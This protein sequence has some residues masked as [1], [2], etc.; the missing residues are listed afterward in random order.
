MRAKKCT[1]FILVFELIFLLT[2]SIFAQTISINEVVSANF[3]SATDE[4]GDNPD[5]LELYNYGSVP[6]NLMNFGLSDRD[7]ELHR[8]TFPDVTID[9]YDFLLVFASNKNRKISAYW[10]TIIDEGDNWKYFPGIQAPPP[11]WRAVTFNDINWLEGPSGFGAGDG[12]DNTVIPEIND[13]IANSVFLRHTFFVNNVNNILSALLNIDFDDAFVVWLN[14]VEIARENIGY[15]GDFP[16]YNDSIGIT[17]HEA[18]LYS[19]GDANYYLLEDIQ[20]LLQPGNNTLAIE[21]HTLDTDMTMIPFLTLG[22]ASEPASP[23]GVNPIVQS[24]IPNLHT[25][26]KI[27][28]T[29]IIYL[30]DANENE[31]DQLSAEG[32]MTDVSRG[33]QPDG[34]NNIYLF[35]ITTPD[36]MNVAIPATDILDPPEF[37]LLGGYYD[38]QVTIT[39]TGVNAEETIYVSADGSVPSDTSSTSIIYNNPIHITET[40]VLRARKY[41]SGSIPSEVVTNTYFINTNHNLP[42]ISLTSDPYNLFDFNYGIL[43]LGPNAGSSFPHLKA[44]FWQDWERPMHIELFE[45]DGTLGLKTD[46]G[47]KVFGYASRGHDQKSLA[48][49]ARSKYGANAFEYKFFEDK[50][51]DSFQSFVLR[52]SGGDWLQ[53][54]MRD[55]LM[56]S[57]LKDSN[58]SYQA[59]RPAVTYINGEYWGIYGIREKMNEHYYAA[60]WGVDPDNIDYLERN[61]QPIQGDI[62]NYSQMMDYIQTHELSVPEYYEHVCTLMDI[63]N[64]IS[65]QVAQ[66]YYCNTDWPGENIKYW[67]ERV[68]DAKW[69][70]QIYDLDLGMW[71]WDGPDHNTL[72]FALAEDGP[73][74]YAYPN[75][76][77]AT[78]LFRQ[79]VKNDVFV[80]KLVNRF[81]DYMNSI[82][83]AQHLENLVQ[84]NFEYLADEMQDHFAKWGGDYDL[85]MDNERLV[86][87]YFAN[88]RPGFMRTFITDQFELTGGTFDI[89]ADATKIE[90]G[91]VKF[92]TVVVDSFPWTGTYFVDY[93]VT[94]TA[95]P[96]DGYKFT[97]WTG[98]VTSNDAT[99]TLSQDSNIYLYANFEFDPEV[100]SLN[101]VINEVNYNSSTEMNAGD[102]VEIYNPTSEEIDLSGW[103]FKDSDDTHDFEFPQ[104]YTLGAQKYVVLCQDLGAFTAS[105]PDVINFMGQIDFGL[106]ASGESLRLMDNTMALIDSVCYGVED[107]WTAEPN[108]N[109][110]TLSLKNAKMDNT[111]AES[112]SAS[113]G[114]GTPGTVNDNWEPYPPPFSEKLAILQNYPNP[115]REYSIIEYSIP[116]AGKVR[117]AIYNLKGQ[118]V[119]KLVNE[120]QEPGAYSAIWNGRNSQNKLARSGIYF[121]LL[122]QNGK[123]KVGKMILVR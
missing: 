106:S 49:F 102:W 15:Y 55:G 63:E 79:L 89:Y 54:N 71:L 116:I 109:G 35:N 1:I 3:N 12:D 7:N 17:V 44:N 62:S 4:D 47:I 93:P 108:G 74:G 112:W 18:E 34:A 100:S 45:P 9:P 21:V 70:W 96:A 13:D 2:G 82:F 87:I 88:D 117:L 31:I 83:S 28:D 16:A 32:L 104:H 57:N 46:C 120:V 52:N 73:Y 65:Y 58:L 51:Y 61:R 60:N 64:Y 76:P 118:I 98:D 48:L 105:Y 10:E 97:G 95:I 59:Y 91:T 8:W 56:A 66:I 113:A 111:L 25:N 119:K 69:R 121:Y 99:I 19:G 42:V 75:A 115:F 50:P 22:Y 23:Q 80:E 81:S 24:N 122:Q 107:P 20:S 38:G 26:F 67:R 5:W 37:N 123:S 110:P 11:N 40:K 103:H 84:E 90:W 30:S 39:L 68:P 29:D 86:M 94:A 53:S 92:N 72:S 41:K 78:Y 85:W 101:L 36:F 77:W 6:V 43:A 27:G 14:E 114:Y 33:R